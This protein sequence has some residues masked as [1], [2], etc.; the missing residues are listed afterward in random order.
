[1]ATQGSGARKKFEGK[2]EHVVNY[3]LLPPRSKIMA[4][5]GIRRKFDD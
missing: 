3:F 2:P 1:M 5:L 4:Q